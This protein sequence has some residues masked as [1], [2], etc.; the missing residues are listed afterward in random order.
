MGMEHAIDRFFR[1]EFVIRC[2]ITGGIVFRV[3]FQLFIFNYEQF[4]NCVSINVR[5]KSVGAHYISFS[6]HLSNDT[7]I[8]LKFFL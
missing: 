8:S 6:V 5:C 2:N 4:S 1:Y 3:K 7:K